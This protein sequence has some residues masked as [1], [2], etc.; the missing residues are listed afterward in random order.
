MLETMCKCD[1]S[2]PCHHSTCQEQAPCL[3]ILDRFRIQE[4]VGHSRVKIA[5]K[6]GLWA[7]LSDFLVATSFPAPS[8]QA[9]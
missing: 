8:K 7:S 2:I 6:D 1:K 3:E 9:P 5:E 4:E